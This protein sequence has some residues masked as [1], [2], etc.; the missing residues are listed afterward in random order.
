MDAFKRAMDIDDMAEICDAL[1][2]EY[3]DTLILLYKRGSFSQ[4]LS[5]E[6][7]ITSENIETT[8]IRHKS[9]FR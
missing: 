4:I 1:N 7:I 3:D 6:K 9:V 5:N 2:T 8:S